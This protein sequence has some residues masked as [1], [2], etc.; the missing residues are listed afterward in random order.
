MLRSNFTFF[1][2]FYFLICSSFIP[3][4]SVE[5]IS[6]D[7][8]SK[9]LNK[10]KSV[11]LNGEV[12]YRKTGGLMVTHFVK[13]FESITI[14]NSNGE[15]KVYDPVNN[16]ILQTQGYDLSSNNSFFYFFMSGKTQDM[17][18]SKAGFKLGTTKIED[19]MVITN[20]T[21]P[22]QMMSELSKAELVHEKT[23][24]I[25]MAFYSAKGKIMEKIYYTN[26]QKVG[27]IMLPFNITEFQYDGKGDSTIIRRLYSNPKINMQ[28]NNTY[29]NY[30]IPANAKPIQTIN[31]E[32]K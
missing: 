5:V 21:P 16:T 25:F 28:V 18:L 15:V 31:Q 6:M 20:W 13:P 12:F 14:S 22:Q 32:K 8:I 9:T 27:D 10:G 24:P 7:M 2:L 29:L 19:K 23:Q 1:I 30:K 11:T 3:Q 17:G 26:Y 4:G